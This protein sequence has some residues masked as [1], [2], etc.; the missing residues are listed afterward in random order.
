M[1]ARRT[2]AHMDEL[3]T[4]L[5]SQVPAIPIAPRNRRRRQAWKATYGDYKRATSALST[6]RMVVSSPTAW[7]LMSVDDRQYL[8]DRRFMQGRYL[9]DDE[10]ST[11]ALI[12]ERRLPLWTALFVGVLGLVAEEGKHPVQPLVQDLQLTDVHHDVLIWALKHSNMHRRRPHNVDS[13]RQGALWM[14]CCEG[15]F[16][17]RYD[18]EWAGK[19]RRQ[20]APLFIPTAD[21][22][23]DPLTA[24]TTLSRMGGV[25]MPDWCDEQFTALQ[26]RLLSGEMTRLLQESINNQPKG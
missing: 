22:A 16:T 2:L 25:D 19:I 1:N 17:T 21:A 14:Y 3:F 24:A 18:V 20:H 23:T 7:P 6:E 15:W 12:I 11:A 26:E 10:P 5:A 13:M 9:N 8:I 4:L